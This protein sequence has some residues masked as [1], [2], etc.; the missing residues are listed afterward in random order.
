VGAPEFRRHPEEIRGSSAFATGIFSP[1]P[2]SGARGAGLLEGSPFSAQGQESSPVQHPQ[3]SA[4]CGM[5]VATTAPGTA[6][7]IW[8]INP[9]IRVMMVLTMSV[10]RIIRMTFYSKEFIEAGFKCPASAMMRKSLD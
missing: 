3:D 10:V 2:A 8:K 4:S 7:V 9:R 5:G 6:W 1:P